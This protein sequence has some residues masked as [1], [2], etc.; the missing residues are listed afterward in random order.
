MGYIEDIIKS[1]LGVIY[2]NEDVSS[3]AGEDKT[4]GGEEAA[5]ANRIKGQDLNSILSLLNETNSGGE[6]EPTGTDEYK[7]AYRA[8]VSAAGIMDDLK[9]Y[10]RL[11]SYDKGYAD[12]LIYGLRGNLAS[13]EDY[14]HAKSK[15]IFFKHPITPKGKKRFACMQNAL[16]IIDAAILHYDGIDTRHD[17]EAIDDKAVTANQ[18]KQSSFEVTEQNDKLRKGLDHS[19]VVHEVITVA[20][21]MGENFF[22]LDNLTAFLTMYKHNALEIPVK[23]LLMR[24][25][26]PAANSTVASAF[27][28]G[29]PDLSN[30]LK[31]AYKLLREVDKLADELWKNVESKSSESNATSPDAQVLRD[32]KKDILKYIRQLN[33]YREINAK[34]LNRYENGRFI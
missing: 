13:I 6:E 8:V 28:L 10:V 14:L 33:I 1:T 23:A 4:Y 2:D 34:G 31:L 32:S 20:A 9:A 12:A 17:N 11:D 30:Q 26:T 15:G 3:L 19:E 16:R 25:N 21:H 7:A 22:N 18:Q 5:A 27:K 29:G 24:E